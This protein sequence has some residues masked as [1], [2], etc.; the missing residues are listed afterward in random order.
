MQRALGR[1]Q[2]AAIIPT[3]SERAQSQ[4]P[5]PAEWER[6]KPILQR[7]Y[8]VEK[9]PL[10]DVVNILDRQHGFRATYVSHHF[11]HDRLHTNQDLENGCLRVE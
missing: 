4:G 6:I 8:V 2:H 5:N 11:G 1:S 9:R 7:L 10:R 3:V